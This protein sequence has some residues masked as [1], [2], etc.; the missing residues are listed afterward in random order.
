MS[1]SLPRDK[2]LSF[3]APGVSITIKVKSLDSL[4]WRKLISE[5][6]RITVYFHPFDQIGGFCGNDIIRHYNYR[7]SF[8]KP[9]NP[10]ML[11]GLIMLNVV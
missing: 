9:Y 3:D 4:K 8:L 6:I 11:W 10:D 5:L 1:V 2:K 7:F